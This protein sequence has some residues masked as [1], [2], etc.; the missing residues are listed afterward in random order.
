MKTTLK[1]LSLF[2][3]L[4]LIVSCDSDDDEDDAPPAN[5]NNMT[6][7][8][9]TTGTMNPTD[10]T[11]TGGTMNDELLNYF[12]AEFI[13]VF[14]DG[15]EEQIS[16]PAIDGVTFTNGSVVLKAA[17]QD[18]GREY[19]F[20]DFELVGLID[21]NFLEVDDFFPSQETESDF[22]SD[23]MYGG[24]SRGATIMYPPGSFDSADQSVLN[25][26]QSEIGRATVTDIVLGTIEVFGFE[27]ENKIVEISGTF[28][29]TDDRGAEGT[30]EIKNGKFRVEHPDR[31]Q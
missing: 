27:I 29:F 14:A 4:G 9:D 28:S 5:S 15:T 23:A 30:T 24:F 11:D 21:P 17:L 3:I 7:P 6:N 31:V 8:T 16:M 12:G 10:T 19:S 22:V 18:M 1:I 25:F 26:G 13:Y 2:I 20:M